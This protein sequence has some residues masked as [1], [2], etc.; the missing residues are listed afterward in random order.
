MQKDFSQFFHKRKS[1]APIIND[2]EETNRNKM[3]KA[4]PNGNIFKS[5]SKKATI[6][7]PF[8]FMTEIRSCIRL[9]NR[10]EEIVDRPIFKARKIP[11]SLFEH[12]QCQK[13]E[14]EPESKELNTDNYPTLK[15]KILTINDEIDLENCNFD[16]SIDEISKNNSIMPLNSSQ[17]TLRY[18][19]NESEAEL[20]EEKYY[21]NDKEFGMI[22]DKTEKQEKG[23]LKTVKFNEL[24]GWDEKYEQFTKEFID[25]LLSLEGAAYSETFDEK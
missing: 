19:K 5:H 25:K 7:E 17:H 8:F 15:E 1:S 6:P 18:H 20:E 3:L 10:E 11:K 2:F 14:L 24:H 22:L 21:E 4:A 12:L 13:I 23:A 9:L 16:E